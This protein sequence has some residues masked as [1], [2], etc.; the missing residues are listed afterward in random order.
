MKRIPIILIL[1]MLLGGFV[2][3][4]DCSDSDDD[5]DDDNDDNT[6][7][8]DD[9]T[10]D[11][12]TGD[13]DDDDDDSVVETAQY[14]AGGTF[15]GAALAMDAAGNPYVV[16]GRS[17]QLRVYGY[18]GGQWPYTVADFG[19]YA[20]PSAATGPDGSLHLAYY[21]WYGAYLCY[22]T[23]QSGEWAYEIVDE[24]GD[25]GHYSAVAVDTD[26]RVHIAYN[27]EV[28]RDS[29]AARYAVQTAKG[30]DVQ[31]VETASDVGAFPAIAVDGSGVVYVTYN[32]LNN[33]EIH[34]SR[35]TGA[36]WEVSVLTD[37]RPSGRASGLAIDSENQLH[38]VY[39]AENTSK[40]IQL[41]YLSGDWGSLTTEV[42]DDSSSIGDSVALTVDDNDQP[43]IAYYNSGTAG[44][45]YATLEDKAWAVE[46]LGEGYPVYIKARSANQ[47]VISLGN[48]G[49]Y[50][51][52]AE[53]SREYIDR[54][55]AVGD[56][57]LAVDDTGTLHVAFLDVTSQS[58][59]YAS[60]FGG[61]W[62]VETLLSAIGGETETLDMVLDADGAC[63]IS[64]YNDM[65]KELGHITNAAGSWENEAV[66]AE[67]VVGAY[68]SIAV[69]AQGYL[70]IS[71]TDQTEGD[72]KYATNSSGDWE[73]F[74][75]DSEGIVG[76]QSAIAVDGDGVVHIVYNDT[77]D[78]DINYALGNDDDWT[79]E[80]VDP[81]GG[82]FMSLYIDDSGE[83]HLAY[84]GAGLRYTTHEMDDWFSR[85]IDANGLAA[86]TSIVAAPE[87]NLCIAYQSI[88]WDL[89]YIVGQDGEWSTQVVDDIGDVG[90]YN[91]MV[92]GSD[93]RR[94]IAYMA[95]WA[96]WLAVIE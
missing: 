16:S 70:H 19:V 60:N 47:V 6:P 57:A 54:G 89:S 68:N 66:D 83:A 2:V 88:D 95:E 56:N 90:Q 29:I 35:N 91:S 58:L 22:A 1:L 74:V 24:D 20:N 23:N 15:S 37:S 65:T 50:A 49:V 38:V 13:D 26:G 11:D 85:T 77:S 41:N 27:L 72:L 12:D 43:H 53:W 64:Y 80:V 87:E 8:D 71:Y 31:T 81:D 32:D 7:D 34:L 82:D 76:E 36:S 45:M 4:C 10:S 51:K 96:L 84:S 5:D 62:N 78:N 25:V 18:S 61:T 48:I 17:R 73:T 33:G 3:G 75:V 28:S 46:E 40:G 67:G 44:T 92:R 14:I 52:L 86:D 94:Y 69:D 30:W 59:M 93:G 42:V 63:H 39:R 9:D 21:D 79:L 55:Y